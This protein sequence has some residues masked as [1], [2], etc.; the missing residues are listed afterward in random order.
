MSKGNIQLEDIRFIPTKT[1]LMSKIRF[2]QNNPNVMSEEK[3]QAFEKVITKYGFAKDPWLNEQKDGAYLVIDG[4]QGIR[5]M[6]E[7]NVKEFQAKI[8]HVSYIQVRMLRQ[9]ANKLHGEHDKIK[10]A[11]EYRAI[12][13]DDNLEEFAELLAESEDEFRETINQIDDLSFKPDDIIEENIE[14]DINKFS[15]KF[16]FANINDYEFALK[17]LKSINENKEL[18]FLKLAG[19]N[20]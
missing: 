12:F 14:T 17:K 6:Q 20:I 4:E 9:I 11:D 5:R 3:H 16:E 10:D 13:D 18:A 8:F 2:D 7:H 1:V 15:I 19:K